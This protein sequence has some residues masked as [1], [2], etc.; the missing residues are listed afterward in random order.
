ME[1]PF[2][3]IDA[4]LATIEEILLRLQNANRQNIEMPTIR[5]S[6]DINE[7]CEFVGCSKQH[8]YRLTS[9]NRVPHFTRGKKLWFDRDLIEAWLLENRRATQGEA[10]AAANEYL[11]SAARRTR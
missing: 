4:R 8:A 9:A 1:N 2:E 3:L 6:M 5:R 11:Q 10:A 7:F